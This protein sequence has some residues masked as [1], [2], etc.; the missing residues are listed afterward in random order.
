M[1][2][3]DDYVSW[4]NLDRDNAYMERMKA[5]LEEPTEVETK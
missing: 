3:T 4:V 1:P 5:E 2:R